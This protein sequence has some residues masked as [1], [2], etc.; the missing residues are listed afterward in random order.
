M[1]FWLY[2]FY[3]RRIILICG[4]CT[5]TQFLN[6]ITGATGDS[7]IR[8]YAFINTFARTGVAPLFRKALKSHF[9]LSGPCSVAFCF[10]QGFPVSSFFF[11]FLLV[12][13]LIQIGPTF[14]AAS[15][16]FCSSYTHGQLSSDRGEWKLLLARC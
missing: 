9:V 8:D 12:T 15:S 4:K 10:I 6:S 1:T 3:G 2:H 14:G 5:V 11:L 16:S 13:N 7:M